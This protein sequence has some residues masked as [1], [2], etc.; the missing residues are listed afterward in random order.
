MVCVFVCVAHGIV[1]G[2]GLMVPQSQH[3]YMLFLMAAHSHLGDNEH[4]IVVGIERAASAEFS[5]IN[6]CERFYA[7]FTW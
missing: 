5:Y 7:R 1:F 4:I 2:K 6:E 3:V